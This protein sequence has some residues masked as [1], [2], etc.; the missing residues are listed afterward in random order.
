MRTGSAAVKLRE[1]RRPSTTLEVHS[2]E[3]RSAVVASRATGRRQPVLV[4][5][6]PRSGTTWLARLL[7]SAPRTALAGREPMNPRDGGYGLAKTIDSWVR[8]SDPSPRQKRALRS[9][10]V[11]RNPLCFGRYGRRQWAAPLPGTRVIVKDPFALLSLRTIAS[12]TGARIVLVYRHPAAVLTSYRSMGW[13]HDLGELRA[14]LA[15]EP[16]HVRSTSLSTE[17]SEAEQFGAFW[18]DLHSAALADR[19]HVDMIVISHAELAGGGMAAAE[20]VFESLDLVPG[21]RLENELR[22]NGGP[23]DRTDGQRL[24]DFDRDPARV[25]HRWRDQ[26]DTDELG[27]VERS[28]RPVLEELDA[29]RLR[30]S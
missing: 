5:G 16:A 28:A 24:H 15:G 6:V 1:L 27:D 9:A 4:T 8:L 18:A 12:L 2:G 22:V 26:I 20:N 14:V 30:L 23:A 13:T 11:G 21:K 25:A 10:F 19:E 3:G 7:T 17:P 29:I